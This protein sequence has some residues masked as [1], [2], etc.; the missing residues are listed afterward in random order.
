MALLETHFNCLALDGI[1][2]ALDII[3]YTDLILTVNGAQC[4]LFRCGLR[5]CS[6][7]HLDEL[8]L[9]YVKQGR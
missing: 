8:A 2:Y 9:S 7:V 6:Q 1:D 3:N 4:D 5:Y